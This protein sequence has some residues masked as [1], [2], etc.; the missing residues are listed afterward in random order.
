MPSRIVKCIIPTCPNT[1]QHRIGKKCCGV[2]CRKALH[3]SEQADAARKLW[4]A[5]TLTKP[6]DYPGAAGIPRDQ[7]KGVGPQIAIGISVPY[8]AVSYR[9]GAPREGGDESGR[10]HLKWFPN[11]HVVPRGVFTLQPW[12]FPAVPFPGLYLVA[13]FDENYQLVGTPNRLVEVTITS[14]PEPWHRG[15]DVMLLRRNRFRI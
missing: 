11:Y 12:V 8:T 2:Q 9:L 10:W 5:A 14:S 3:Y 1:F 6:V 4:T 13:Y 7:W 15:D